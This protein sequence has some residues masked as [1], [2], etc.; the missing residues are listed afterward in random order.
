M[1]EVYLKENDNNILR[2]P[3][4]PT[5]VGADGSVETSL[6][7]INEMGEVSLFSGKNLRTCEVSSFFPNRVYSFCNYSDFKKPYEFVRMLEKW[8]YEGAKLR[9]IV[10]DTHTNI[11]MMITSFNYKEQDGT[12]DVY[13]NISLVEYREIKLIRSSDKPKPSENENNRPNDNKPSENQNKTHK[14]VKGDSLWSIAQKYYGKGSDYPKIKD[15]N[16][17]KYKSLEKNNIIY[18]NWELVV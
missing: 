3:I 6:E 18:V 2:F 4:T 14:V 13:F 8:M 7:K 15:K 16:K 1:I 11:P 9:Y 10:S 5:E 17:S 12:R